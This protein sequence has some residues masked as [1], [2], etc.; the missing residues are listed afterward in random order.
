[1]KHLKHEPNAADGE[2]R[3]QKELC[4]F[5]HLKGSPGPHH[6]DAS[7]LRLYQYEQS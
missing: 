7:T 2:F 3:P 1:M 4:L 5:A 6:V